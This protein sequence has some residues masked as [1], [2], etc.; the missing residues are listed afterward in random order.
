[1]A[2]CK[3]CRYARMGLAQPM[4]G[5]CIYGVREIND[6]ESTTRSGLMMVPG[7][8]INLRNE[9]CEHYEEKTSHKDFIRESN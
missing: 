7:K 6:K 3:T 2:K 1:M 4:E 9:A 5:Y 8:M